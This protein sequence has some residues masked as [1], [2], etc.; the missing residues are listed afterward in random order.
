MALAGKGWWH[1]DAGVK[2]SAKRKEKS[3]CDYERSSNT[4]GM[5]VSEDLLKQRD[6]RLATDDRNPCQMLTGDP[7]SHRSALGKPCSDGAHPTSSRGSRA[8]RCRVTSIAE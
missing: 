2:Y 1:R 6:E 8:V 3:L 7:P 5:K 4:V